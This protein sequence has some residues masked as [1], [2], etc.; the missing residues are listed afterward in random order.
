[1]LIAP[2]VYL[3]YAVPVGSTKLATIPLVQ[4]AS[5]VAPGP[6]QLQIAIKCNL[7]VLYMAAQISPEAASFLNAI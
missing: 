3:C 5:M 4:D 7:G 1:M 2:F 6:P